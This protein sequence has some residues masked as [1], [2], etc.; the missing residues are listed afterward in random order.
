M[1]VVPSS[2]IGSRR[3]SSSTTPS[4]PF[5][6]ISEHSNHNNLNFYVEPPTAELSID[7]FEVYALK[8]L[9]VCVCVCH[10]HCVSYGVSVIRSQCHTHCVSYALRV[11]YEMLKCTT[12]AL[13]FLNISVAIAWCSTIIYT[14]PQK[15]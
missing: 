1:N 15:D 11:S 6:D 7:D 4:K 13:F 8:R 9:K 5:T 14:G 3:R 2:A 12:I 10:T